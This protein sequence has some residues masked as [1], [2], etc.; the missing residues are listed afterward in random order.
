ML[1]PSLFEPCGL[2]QM[3]SAIYGSLPIVHDTGG[4]HDTIVPIDVSKNSGNGILFRDYDSNALAWAFDQAM[5]FSSL[6]ADV[7]RPFIERVMRESKATFNHDVCA[8]AY[9]DMY[10][11]MLHRPL[12]P[13]Q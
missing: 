5:D 3:V 10:E 2:P 12:L 7:R 4:L 9:M 1:M 11:Q 8:R 6:P 13:M